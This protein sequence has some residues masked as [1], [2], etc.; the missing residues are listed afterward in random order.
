MNSDDF[1]ETALAVYAGGLPLGVA[2]QHTGT[3]T[4]PLTW[5]FVNDNAA[6]EIPSK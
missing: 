3:D 5:S 1:W 2:Y 4:Q 6:V